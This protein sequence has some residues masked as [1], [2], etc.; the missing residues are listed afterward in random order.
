MRRLLDRFSCCRLGSVVAHAAGSVPVTLQLLISKLPRFLKLLLSLP[1]AAGK[2][3]VRLGL[4]DIVR[5]LSLG[6][7]LSKPHSA[8][9]GPCSQR[10]S[11]KLHY[12][13]SFAD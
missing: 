7:E 11:V 2:V 5:F 3:P 12:H 13:G 4:K 6:K 10:N 1:Q 8:G 9:R